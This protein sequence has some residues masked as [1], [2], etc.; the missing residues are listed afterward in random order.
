LIFEYLQY[1][2]ISDDE[3]ETRNFTH[4]AKGYLI[5][6]NELYRRSTIGILQLCIH[7]EEGKPILLDIH[8]GKYGHYASSRSMVG[9]AFRQGFYWPTAATDVV[10][11]VRSC[12]GCQY[13]VT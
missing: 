8:E 4:R 7:T 2:A 10:Q 13:F 6:D 1:G 12:K 3:T 5:N 9:K 11:I